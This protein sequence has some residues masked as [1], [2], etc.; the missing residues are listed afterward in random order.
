MRL[1]GWGS[2]GKGLGRKKR[3]KGKGGGEGEEDVRWKF[4]DGDGMGGW[5]GGKRREQE[6][7]LGPVCI[8]IRRI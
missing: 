6:S 1:G 8:K 3:G 7:V 4:G 2:R 5:D